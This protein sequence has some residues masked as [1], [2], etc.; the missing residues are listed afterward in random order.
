MASPEQPAP[1]WRRVIRREREI[2]AAA[3][4]LLGVLAVIDL[5]S[6]R[7]PRLLLSFAPLT[8]LLLATI[9]RITPE[10]I[11][12]WFGLFELIALIAGDTRYLGLAYPVAP[13]AVLVLLGRVRQGRR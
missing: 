1:A 3:A 5:G 12:I 2:A 9:V 13:V 8:F 7:A 4:T 11:A 10:R 6:I